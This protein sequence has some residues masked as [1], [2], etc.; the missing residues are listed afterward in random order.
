M[1]SILSG[2]NIPKERRIFLAF[3]FFIVS[4]FVIYFNSL[5]GEFIGDDVTLIEN[6]IAIQT[7]SFENIIDIF[8]RPFFDVLHPS[9]G[10]TIGMEG[11]A[12]YRPLSLLSYVFD[13]AIWHRIPF[14][15]HLTN[16]LIHILSV[17]FLFI[18]IYDITQH[19]GFSFICATL[20]L[21]HPI[22]SR[23]VSSISGRTDLLCFM[24]FILSLVCYGRYI[25][26]EE[27][28]KYVFLAC[29]IVSFILALL[30]KEMAV[31][32]PIIIF[33]YDLCFNKVSFY[34]KWKRRVSVYSIFVI[35]LFI[36]LYIRGN[37]V[38]MGFSDYIAAGLSQ[39]FYLRM[40][41]VSD[42]TLSHLKSF[43]LPFNIY[44]SWHYVPLVSSYFGIEFFIFSFLVT[45]LVC[46]LILSWQKDKMIFFGIGWFC[47]T[48]FPVS[49]VVPI[50]LTI[51]RYNLFTGEQFM[52]IPMIGIILMIVKMAYGYENLFSNTIVKNIIKRILIWIF[53]IIILTFSLLTI[54]YNIAWSNAVYYNLKILEQIPNSIEARISLGVAYFRKGEIYKALNLFEEAMHMQE[55]RG[56]RERITPVPYQNLILIHYEILENLDKAKSLCYRGLDIFPDYY[57]FYYF[58]AEIHFK[59]KNYRQAIIYSKKTLSINPTFQYCIQLLHKLLAEYS[60]EHQDIIQRYR[61]QIKNSP[62]N[63]NAFIDLGKFYQSY[64]LFDRAIDYY[65]EALRI[66]PQS[67][68]AI[69]N[70]SY[71]FEQLSMK[72]NSN[73]K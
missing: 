7:V 25:Y 47:I 64:Y 4:A 67:D 35:I 30:S 10:R 29:S 68:V 44:Y 9:L 45:I 62:K 40:L 17:I 18:L 37:V 65:K 28:K 2:L 66:E 39:D 51:A 32:L 27:R 49:N 19:R 56:M 5:N 57:I 33:L 50:Y 41:T 38:D 16:L 24:F 8:S 26:S 3:I 1:F 42:I 59:E 54:Y 48:Y 21:T 43:L 46:S 70:L 34:K 55:A 73:K 11:D 63:I 12:Y 69:S 6:N 20:F 52:H 14:G 36:Y 60:K 53:I 22:S 13:Y 61:K 72:Y 15:Y 71:C 31:S 23:Y 58:L